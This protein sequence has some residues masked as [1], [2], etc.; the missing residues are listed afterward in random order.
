MTDFSKVPDRKAT[1]V[2]QVTVQMVITDKGEEGMDYMIVAGAAIAL[3][4]DLPLGRSV[5]EALRVLDALIFHEKHGQ[6]C[7][8]NW[9]Q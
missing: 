9:K 8:A 4:N 5:D 7:P 1:T 3:I 2:N 6:V